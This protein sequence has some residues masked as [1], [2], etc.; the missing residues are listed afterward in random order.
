LKIFRKEESMNKKV[1]ALLT[2]FFI[3]L[4][5]NLHASDIPYNL[6]KNVAEH[7]AVSVFGQGISLGPGIPYYDIEDNLMGYEFG[8]SFRGT[9]P[10][11]SALLALLSEKRGIVE[12]VESNGGF[13]DVIKLKKNLAGI[14]SYGRIFVSVSSGDF[15]VPELGEGLPPYYR[16]YSQAMAVARD[17]LNGE[18]SFIRVYYLT[19]WIKWY[20][21]SANGKDVFVREQSL[22]C[23]RPQ[24]IYS[25]H[26]EKCENYQTLEK[27]HRRIWKEIRSGDYSSIQMGA[28][29]GYIDS[30]PEYDW[31]YGCTPTASAMVMGYWD[32]RGYDRLVDWYFN[33]YDVASSQLVLNV[34][35]V[36]KELAIAMNTDTTTGGTSIYAIAGGH[37]V[38]ANN[39]NGYNFSAERSPMGN[40]GNDFV[41]SW[42]TT[43][44]DGGRP[45]N[46]SNLYYWFQN[47]FIHHSVT[48]YGYT[49]DKYVYIF[50]TWMWG[51][52]LWYYYT[53][54][55]GTYSQPWV[56]T[57]VPGGSEP[58][59]VTLI[60]PDGGEIWYAA[61]TE[62]VE[63]TTEG[64]SV[65]HLGIWFSSNGGEDWQSLANNAPNTG[66]FDWYV[67]PDSLS[68]Y[69]ARIRLEAYDS[70]SNL[71]GA[72][73]SAKDFTVRPETGCTLFVTDPNGGEIWAVG[74]VH[75]ITWEVNG[76][77]PHH[78]VI[79][80]SPDGGNLWNNIITYPN[81]GSFDWTIPDDT[82]S[83]ALVKVR[84]LTQSNY[85]LSEDISDDYFTI[86]A[87]GINEEPK[88][89]EIEPFAVSI[90]PVPM[91]GKIE[92]SVK[93]HRSPIS[94]EIVDIS[95]RVVRNLNERGSTIVWDG[96]DNFGRIVQSGIF[97]YKL[98]AGG[99][100]STGK[101]VKIR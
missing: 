27:Y 35:N 18:P 12:E 95:G 42:I 44:V 98:T 11:E 96:K 79:S 68:T 33:H 75:Q 97:I 86:A 31:S 72:D 78:V 55:S 20:R 84:G 28:R 17:Y 36:Q 13:Q 52:Q 89:V 39:Y 32:E 56:I 101:I 16:R 5:C 50:T 99:N 76:V 43:E 14:G 92:F 48:G 30:V 34:P 90:S 87:T 26:L 83:V 46:W 80:Y 60:T 93:G 73:G 23:D 3:L 21:F 9:F 22:E 85:L 53:Y 67:Q 71:L 65:D 19:P 45:F 54:H 70:G 37:I 4:L 57:A 6:A 82:T 7:K 66:S 88:P 29:A 51:E 25:I 38:V 100:K 1:L 69:R 24:D 91:T 61:S 94:I 62:T 63:W 58:H 10:E 81:S 64:G 77:E 40:T 8:V 47:Q 59:K 41:W 2:L 49:D 15:P 74:E